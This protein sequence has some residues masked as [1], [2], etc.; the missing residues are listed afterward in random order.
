MELVRRHPHRRASESGA[1]AVEFALVVPLLLLI[2]MGVIQYGLW[3]NDSLNVRQGVREGARLGVVQ[4]YTS[5]NA[6]TCTATTSMEKLA[7]ITRS[8]V[9]AVGGTT[10]VRI[11]VPS[12]NGGWKRTNDLTVC[13]MVTFDGPGLLPVPGDGLIRSVT[14][15]SIEVA[16]PTVPSGTTTPFGTPAGADWSWCT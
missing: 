9:G 1:S 2:V 16:T 14:H 6:S 5:Y 10:Y 15:M 7:C 11:I 12:T 13:S 4:N 8:Q 3:F